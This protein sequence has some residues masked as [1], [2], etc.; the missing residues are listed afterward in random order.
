MP[1]LQ[2]IGHTPADN[3]ENSKQRDI[4]VTVGHGMNADL[5]QTDH[6]YQSS[7]E[8]EPAHKVRAAAP[9]DHRHGGQREDLQ[10]NDSS[11][12]FR[13]WH[14]CGL[15]TD[16]RGIANRPSTP[17]NPIRWKKLTRSSKRSTIAIGRS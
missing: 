16:A 12:R 6:G 5:Y 8:P 10:A 17:S 4:S 9:K 3:H 11:E 2:Q 15:R 1:T 14:G 13:S 7:Q